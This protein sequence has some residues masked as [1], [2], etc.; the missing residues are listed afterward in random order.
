MHYGS[1]E[2]SV[3]T[4]QCLKN[5]DQPLPYDEMD[6]QN[7]HAKIMSAYYNDFKVP[8]H[9]SLSTT[10]HVNI[11]ILILVISPVWCLT[12]EYTQPIKLKNTKLKGFP[13]LIVL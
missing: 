3:D 1:T 9:T 4:L 7:R 12:P 8:Q 11:W 10:T 2:Q 5:L 6:E 13:S